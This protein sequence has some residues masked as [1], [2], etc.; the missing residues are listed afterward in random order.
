MAAEDELRLTFSFEACLDLFTTASDKK[1]SLIIE[2]KMARAANDSFKL[3]NRKF[4]YMQASCG[5]SLIA[6]KK[7]SKIPK[8]RLISNQ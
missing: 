6:K 5:C 7:R 4:F 1:K 3:D 8:K 2:I